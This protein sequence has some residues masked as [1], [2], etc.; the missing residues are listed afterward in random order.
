MQELSPK[1]SFSFPAF[2]IKCDYLYLGIID[3]KIDARVWNLIKE[4]RALAKAT[5]VN[6]VTKRHAS[7]FKRVPQICNYF[8]ANGNQAL[9]DRAMN[10]AYMIGGIRKECGTP[11][12]FTGI[13]VDRLMERC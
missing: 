9:Q 8:L 10:L 4:L 6:I 1:F 5:N 13:I 3:S 11:V 2:N 12:C 7:Y